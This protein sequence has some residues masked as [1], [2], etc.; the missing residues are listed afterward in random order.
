MEE[1]VLLSE[2]LKRMRNDYDDDQ[3]K[4]REIERKRREVQLE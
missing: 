1:E 2:K 3:L 4:M